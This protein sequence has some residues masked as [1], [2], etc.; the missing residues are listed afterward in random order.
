[1]TSDDDITV[2]TTVFCDLFE[3]SILIRCCFLSSLAVIL[4]FSDS[5][6]T[7]HTCRIKKQNNVTFCPLVE[8]QADKP[9]AA[10]AQVWAERPLAIVQIVAFLSWLEL[11]KKET[12]NLGEPAGD[13]NW[14]PLGLKP[15]DPETWE[16]VQLRELKNGRLAMIAVSGMLATESLNGM[17]VIEMWKLGAV[18]PF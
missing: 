14:D 1:M 13:F 9:L 5:I 15:S 3:A 12:G 17:G 6:A 2:C 4:L 11:R 18:N 16:K 10:L 7:L 8:W